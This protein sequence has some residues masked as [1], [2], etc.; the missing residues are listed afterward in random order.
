MDNNSME[1]IDVDEDDEEESAGAAPRCLTGFSSVAAVGQLI[2]AE[3][4]RDM[5]T[6]LA[7]FDSGSDEDEK[8]PWG[9]S[10]PG[11]S[12]NMPRDFQGTYEKL[13]ACCF[14]GEASLYTEAQFKRR[15]RVSSA[16]FKRVCQA[17]YGK[18]VFC[19]PDRKDA[20][21]KKAMHPLVRITA[22]Q[23][24]LAC[25]AAA[26]C[27][28][29]NWQIAETTMD[30]A[31]KSFCRLLINEFGDQ[32]LNRT[33]AEEER[34]RMLNKSAARGFPG[35]FASWDCK[36]FVWDKCPVA[37]QGQHEG[38]SD[39]GKCTKTLEA[40]AD[41][42]CY[43]WFVNFGD[44]GSL[45]DIDALDK[46][47]IVGALISGQLNLK[48]EPCYVNG[49]EQDWMHF[50]VNGICPEWA[51]F[52]KTIPS[53]SQRNDHD[54]RFARKQEAFRKD[55]ERA[56]G[57]LAK[58][59][60]CLARP[61][62]RWN[63]STIRNMLCACVILHNMTVEERV[64]ELHGTAELTE[65]DHA[66]CYETND[67]RNNNVDPN[68]IFA[69]LPAVN[70][71]ATL[72]DVVNQRFARANNLHYLVADRELHVKLKKDLHADLIKRSQN[73]TN[74]N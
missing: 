33:P 8:G 72:A 39:G 74:N 32:H 54:K 48:T 52:V 7:E 11:R 68:S 57:T 42:Q 9:G 40:I 45:N 6:L 59:C 58:K 16:T 25:G 15:F 44:P 41:D 46:S 31:V 34:K 37:L 19:P 63:E 53:S 50:L 26:D 30:R 1:D 21:G 62:R 60:H 24:V 5:S 65:E 67:T 73:K 20:T 27:A 18:G 4:S 13:S 29:E 28:G 17:L 70:M 12:P 14:S 56:F 38:H 61:I 36:H 2:L 49:T 64:K 51:M 3:E 43:L 10:R 22:V 69:R 47:T 66:R 23:R 71:E 35:C 55:I